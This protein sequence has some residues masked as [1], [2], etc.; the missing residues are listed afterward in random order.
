MYI[1]DR[2]EGKIVVLENTDTNKTLEVEI[3]KLPIGIKEGTVLTFDDD[4]YIINKEEE[5]K[6]RNKLQNKFNRLK[7]KN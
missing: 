5:N 1:I 7:N 4:K 3:S 6:R 2:I